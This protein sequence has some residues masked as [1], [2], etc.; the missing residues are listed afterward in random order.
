MTR[1]YVLKIIND[2]TKLQE[3]SEEIDLTNE[4]DLN[5]ASSIVAD[6]KDT[7]RTNNNLVA[8]AAPQLGHKDR[9]FCI[10]FANGDIRAFINPLI[11]ANKDVHLSRETQIGLDNKE[12]IVPR[13]T[14]V[15][16]AYQTPLGK[17]EVN[18]FKGVVSEVF[19]Q[20]VN[21]LD[22]ILLED[23]GLI[24]LDGFDESDEATK[25]KLLVCI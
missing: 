11:F 6:L 23:F 22:G 3:R 7:L 1:K 13:S 2:K 20:M 4:K 15:H 19:Q 16:A 21:L 14:E 18:A 24:V 25:K 10:K 5:R 17:K 9:I 8:L 12:Y